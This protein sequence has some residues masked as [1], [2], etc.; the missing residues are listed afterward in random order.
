MAITVQPRKRKSGISYW[1]KVTV[2]TETDIQTFRSKREAQAWAKQR[3]AELKNAKGYDGVLERFSQLAEAYLN[4][5]LANIDKKQTHL[6]Y[7]VE[8]LGKKK[9]IDITPPVITREQDHLRTVDNAKGQR[10]QPASINRYM[11]TLSHCLKWGVQRGWLT[12]NPAQHLSR[13]PEDNKRDRWLE[14][15]EQKKLFEACKKSRNPQLARI[16][17]FA[18]MTGLRRGEIT[19]AKWGD[20]KNDTLRIPKTKNKHIHLVPVTDMLRR[21]LSRQKQWCESKGGESEY[22]FPLICNSTGQILNEPIGD[23]YTS[24]KNAVKLAGIDNFVFHSL[25]HSAGTYMNMTGL[26]YSITSRALGHMDANMAMRYQHHADQYVNNAFDK[27]QTDNL[28]GWD[29]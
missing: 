27:M 28:G 15:E 16:V 10:F 26:P 11:A 17:G 29:E 8:R 3:E 9:L 23:F 24:F 18:L 1:T 25:R 13:L 2:R 14:P 21:L 20:I 6:K 22:I 7:W 12:N 4:S 5:D 19:N